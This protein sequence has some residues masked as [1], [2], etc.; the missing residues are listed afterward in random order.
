MEQTQE[1]QKPA[2]PWKQASSQELEEFS[3]ANL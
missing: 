3:Q 2:S 1:E